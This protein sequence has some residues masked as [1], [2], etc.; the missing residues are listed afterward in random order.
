MYLFLY[1]KVDYGR[2]GRDLRRVVR[3]TELG[4]DVEL[5]LRAEFYLLVSQLNYQTVACVCVCVHECMC[6][7][8]RVCVCVCVC[9]Y[10]DEKK[11]VLKSS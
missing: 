10:V 9:V 4:G 1:S 2:L 3:V 5:E 8:V 7:C 6:V 11:I